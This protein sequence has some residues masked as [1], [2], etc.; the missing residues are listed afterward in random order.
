MDKGWASALILINLCIQECFQMNSYD[1]SENVLNK[2][3][4]NV[5]IIFANI[6]LDHYYTA[7]HA[8]FMSLFIKYSVIKLYKQTQHYTNA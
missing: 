6:L 1:F 4:Q 5:W 2:F 8:S 3:E 7:M